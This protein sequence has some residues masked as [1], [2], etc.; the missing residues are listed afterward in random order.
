MVRA[1]KTTFGA[2]AQSPFHFERVVVTREVGWVV[3]SVSQS[4]SRR[5]SRLLFRFV[6]F[7]FLSFRL[8]MRGYGN[9]NNYNLL[10]G[11]ADA[12]ADA[13]ASAAVGKTL[14]GFM[15]PR[16]SSERFIEAMS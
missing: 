4:V 9:V 2:R 16:G 6:S 7:R 14:Y 15:M 3:Q 5:A 1:L 12:D 13:A 10:S 8:T 11:S